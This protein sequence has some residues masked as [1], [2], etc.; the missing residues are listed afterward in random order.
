[1]S[2]GS[3][4]RAIG[5]D[6]AGSEPVTSE[7]ETAGI[8]TDIGDHTAF[9]EEWGDDPEA[10]VGRRWLAPGLA[11]GAPAAW[12][13]AFVWSFRARMLAGAPRAQ[14]LT[15]RAQWAVPV[16]LVAV[17]WLLATRNSTQ[18]ARR[19]GEVGHLLSHESRA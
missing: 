14:W 6:D 13:A 15:W 1:M 12:T 8:E 2:G 18:E 3:N 11:L 17:L 10:D 5:P 4:I 9:E 7:V 19:F 16:L